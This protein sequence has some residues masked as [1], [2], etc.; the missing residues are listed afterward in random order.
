M[1][2]CKTPFPLGNHQGAIPVMQELSTLLYLLTPTDRWCIE[3]QS[4]KFEKLSKI[5]ILVYYLKHSHVMYDSIYG[6]M[7][8]IHGRVGTN[9]MLKQFILPGLFQ[10]VSEAMINWNTTS[11]KLQYHKG[12]VKQ[13]YMVAH[14]VCK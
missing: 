6:A 4:E 11:D 5:H 13:A 1:S 3:G 2:L 14:S 10:I 12:Y 7:W 9:Y 8:S